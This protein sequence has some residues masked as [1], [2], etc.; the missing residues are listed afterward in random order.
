MF[1]LPTKVNTKPKSVPTSTLL[2]KIKVVQMLYSI[3]DYFKPDKN[4]SAH[5]AFNELREKWETLSAPPDKEIFLDFLFRV[6]S[7]LDLLI[8]EN[9]PENLEIIDKMSDFKEECIM[10]GV[11]YFGPQLGKDLQE[12]IR[13]KN[14]LVGM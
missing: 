4:P 11:P 10:V 13:G 12:F 8:G 5:F 2:L 1:F 9:N 14:Y 6:D 7:I 3:K